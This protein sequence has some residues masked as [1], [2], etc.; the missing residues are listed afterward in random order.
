MF[1]LNVRLATSGEARIGKSLVAAGHPWPKAGSLPCR[2]GCNARHTAL[3]LRSAS[4]LV[5]PLLSL[6]TFN[7]APESCWTQSWPIG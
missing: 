7:T 3:A 5:N 6:G 1:P 2:A 4:E